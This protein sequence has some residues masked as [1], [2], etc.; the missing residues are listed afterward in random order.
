VVV[1]VVVGLL[2]F[3]IVVVVGLQ[4]FEIVVDGDRYHD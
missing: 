2:D 4:D 3:G 1:V